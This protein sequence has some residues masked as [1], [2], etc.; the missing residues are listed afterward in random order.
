MRVPD[1][2]GVQSIRPVDYAAG[3]QAQLAA[4][5]IKQNDDL[6]FC[7]WRAEH[8]SALGALFLDT[9]LTLDE[10]AERLRGSGRD[11]TRI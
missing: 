8:T 6:L 2:L 9:G 1:R 10:I 11:F 5:K 7:W 3:L 4:L